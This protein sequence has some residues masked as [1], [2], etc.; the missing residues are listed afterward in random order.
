VSYTTDAAGLREAAAFYRRMAD[1]VEAQG[2]PDR[3][4]ANRTR[5]DNL[6]RRA[7]ALERRAAELEG[8]IQ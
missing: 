4:T 6:E 8:L 2:K 5:A 3:A 7:D 1:V